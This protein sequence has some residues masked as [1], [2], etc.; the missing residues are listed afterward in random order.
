M[1]HKVTSYKL[2]HKLH[3]FG[4]KNKSHTGWWVQE[5]NKPGEGLIFYWRNEYDE[6]FFQGQL[7]PPEELAPG[8]IKAYDCHDLLNHL[9]DKRWTRGIHNFYNSRIPEFDDE[10]YWT[11]TF[12]FCN[13]SSPLRFSNRWLYINQKTF[14]DALASL[15]VLILEND[16]TLKELKENNKV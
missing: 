1:E 16:K 9:K 15:I 8:L 14:Q 13:V 4:F 7:I 6:V 2:S 5:C 11:L 3:E 12:D 10:E